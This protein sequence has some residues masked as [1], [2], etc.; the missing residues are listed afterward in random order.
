MAELLKEWST[1]A[2]LL[3]ASADERFPSRLQTIWVLDVTAHEHDVRGA[4]GRPGARDAEAL[5][6]GLTSSCGKG[7]TGSWPEPTRAP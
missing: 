1:V 6:L 5:L 7:C 3:E 2:P 4:A